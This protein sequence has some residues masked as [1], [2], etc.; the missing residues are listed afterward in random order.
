MVVMV[1][2]AVSDPAPSVATVSFLTRASMSASASDGDP[3]SPL[4]KAHCNGT[5]LG[6]ASER[7]TTMV[8]VAGSKATGWDGDTDMAAV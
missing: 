3:P 6:A 4:K 5:S 2:T 8:H 1:H 7:R